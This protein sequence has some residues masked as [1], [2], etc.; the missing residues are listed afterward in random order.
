MVF[1]A[2]RV[3]RGAP[4]YI[5]PAQGAWEDGAPPSRYFVLYTPVWPEILA[6]VSLPSLEAMRATGRIL[7]SVFFVFALALVVR[8]ARRANR[9]AVATGA[10]LALGLEL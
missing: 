1:E 4:L 6:R 9:G 10:L 7:N 2:S 8:G 3:Q 5:D